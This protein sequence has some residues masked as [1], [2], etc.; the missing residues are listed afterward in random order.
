MNYGHNT[1]DTEQNIE[2]GTHSLGQANLV[3]G[4]YKAAKTKIAEFHSTGI[5]LI[6]GYCVHS[7]CNFHTTSLCRFHRSN[8]LYNGHYSVISGIVVNDPS[9][10]GLKKWS[11]YHGNR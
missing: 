7:I 8:R 1:N 5:V 11:K 4:R 6:W 3:V 2:W 9:Q 10:R